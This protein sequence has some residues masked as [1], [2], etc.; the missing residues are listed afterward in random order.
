M[1]FAYSDNKYIRMKRRSMNLRN[2]KPVRLIVSDV[3]GTLVNTQKSITPETVRAIKIAMDKGIRVAIASG[4]AWN[5][6]ED[7]IQ[8]LPELRYFICT[9]GAVVMDKMKNKQLHREGFNKGEALKLLDNLLEYN[10]YTEA[11]MGASI[12][13]TKASL[14]RVDYYIHEHIRP[15]LLQ[16]RTF[17]NDLRDHL[18]QFDTGPEK[19]Q[20]FY[21][22]EDMKQR[23][24][25]DLTAAKDYYDLLQS[26]E[27]N[28]EFVLPHTTKGSAVKAL[29]ETWGFTSDEIMTIGDSHNDLS[30]LKYAGI[31]VAMGNADSLVKETA[32]YITNDNDTNG[33]A[34]AIYAVLDR[35]EQLGYCS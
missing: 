35:N 20:I 18:E 33:L 13:G 26:S 32:N 1:K 16:T 17:V 10:V 6:M 15:F 9:N 27:G 2:E 23:V 8:K 4:R 25:K 21:G 31:S 3:D 7:V 5:E 34:N 29:G 11:Y 22:D 14:P 19:L 30:M 12:F 24:M 28:L